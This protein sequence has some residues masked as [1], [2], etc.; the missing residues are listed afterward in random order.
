MIVTARAAN[1]LHCIEPEAVAAILDALRDRI[2]KP[3]VAMIETRHGAFR[4]YIGRHKD[5]HLALLSISPPR[6]P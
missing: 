1:Q 6:G 2:P 4:V 5:G 3:G